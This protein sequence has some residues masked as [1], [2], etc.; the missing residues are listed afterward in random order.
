MGDDH[1][2]G[3]LADIVP[4]ATI[5]VCAVLSSRCCAKIDYN[6]ANLPRRAAVH[7]HSGRWPAVAGTCPGVCDDCAKPA[8]LSGQG[9]DIEKGAALA[10]CPFCECAWFDKRLSFRSAGR[11]QLIDA[12]HA[13]KRSAGGISQCRSRSLAKLSGNGA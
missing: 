10:G 6:G 5:W 13:L 12:T 1:D 9:V 7:W 4:D 8:E 2:R 11:S 3:E